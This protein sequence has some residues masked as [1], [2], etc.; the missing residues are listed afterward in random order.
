MTF[1]YICNI[2]IVFMVLVL[3]TNLCLHSMPINF[4]IFSTSSP[5]LT[6]GHN[7]KTKP[8]Q[9]QKQQNQN[10][11]QTKTKQ[12]SSRILQSSCS[13]TVL[14][15]ACNPGRVSHE[16]YKLE[17]SLGLVVTYKTLPQNNKGG[18]KEKEV[19]GRGR[20]LGM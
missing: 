18:E 6:K 14:V 20:A 8:K 1:N 4:V 9:Q 7:P 11:N 15:H 2:S 17:P 12:S 16:H 5:G 3:H 19:G 10:Q 13:A